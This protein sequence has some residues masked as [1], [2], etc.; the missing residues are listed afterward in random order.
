MS[1]TT[2]L[3]RSLLRSSKS[4]PDYNFRAY[5]ARRITA[6]FKANRSLPPTEASIALTEGKAQLELIRRQGI[7]GGLYP[8]EKNV[9][10]KLAGAV[11]K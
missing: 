4:L 6:S 10:E 3:Y 8:Q 2:A 7:V 1:A 9:M 11:R 5:T